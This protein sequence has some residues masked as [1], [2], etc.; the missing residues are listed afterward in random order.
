MSLLTALVKDPGEGRNPDMSD[1]E[2]QVMEEQKEKGF[3]FFF[4]SPAEDSRYWGRIDLAR[5]I[6]KRLSIKK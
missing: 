4:L 3:G 6:R 1:W 5:S 2:T